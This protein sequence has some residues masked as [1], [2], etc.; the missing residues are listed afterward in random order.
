VNPAR[1][2]KPDSQ[3][4]PLLYAKARE[5]WQAEQDDWKSSAEPVVLVDIDLPLGS[6]FALA[7][8]IGIIWLALGAIGAVILLA[9][10][11]L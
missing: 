11:V 10:G 4:N 5:Q 7:V 8:Q 1:R 3:G 6:V 9:L 2:S